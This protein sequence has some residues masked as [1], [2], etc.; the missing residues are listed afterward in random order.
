MLLFLALLGAAALVERRLGVEVVV[1]LGV[2]R[3]GREEEEEGM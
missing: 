3:S 2:L 1:G